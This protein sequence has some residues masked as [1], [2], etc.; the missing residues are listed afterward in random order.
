MSHLAQQVQQL[1]VGFFGRPADPGGS[2]YWG[3]ILHTNPNAIGSI[4]TTFTQSA[5]YQA[6][7]GGKSNAG[8]ID[9]L[10]QNL[11]GHPADTAGRQY[12]SAQ[13]DQG[14]SVGSVL[15]AIAGGA[16]STDRSALDAKLSAATAFTAAL[17]VTTEVLSY[18]GT[19]AAATAREYLA[20]VEDGQTLAATTT[21][22]ALDLVTTDIVLG[23]PWSMPSAVEQQIQ[24]LYI[25]YFARAA[26]PPGQEYWTRLLDGNPANPGLDKISAAFAASAEY[27]DEYAQSTNALKVAAVYQN[28]FSRAAET[29]GIDY[30]AA[31]L[32][33]GS[34]SFDNVVTEVASGA[35]T[36]DL[37]AYDAKVTVAR[38]I[39]DALDTLPEILSYTGTNSN[40]LVKAYIAK[41][42]D[43][44]SY[45][46]AIAPAAIEALIGSFSGNPG[47]MPVAGAIEPVALVGMAPGAA[48][49]LHF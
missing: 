1:Y 45:A 37:Y 24:E 22:F 31:L 12:W 25:A 8:V 10:Y 35:R 48:D 46:A 11:F 36:T 3:G 47:P 38:A 42:K 21:P 29:A 44:E 13:L 7:F 16:L 27:R 49:A 39:T 9:L 43:A 26:D 41:V 6:S 4:G 19:Q 32:D 5:E 33:N 34:I 40:A 2:N 28:L 20:Y 23:I 18:I 15:L 30:W 14:V 17:D